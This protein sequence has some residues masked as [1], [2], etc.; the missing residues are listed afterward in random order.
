MLLTVLGKEVNT[1]ISRPLV[2]HGSKKVKHKIPEKIPVQLLKDHPK[3]GSAGEIVRVRPAFM[4]NYLH[5]GNGA[6][7]LTA[8]QGPRIP[9]VEKTKPKDRKQI[10]ETMIDTD[11]ETE[12]KA[13]PGDANA[14]ALSL[15][16]LSNL[17][18]TM[19]STRKS[20]QSAESSVSHTF[21][22]STEEL[23]Y[24]ASELKQAIPR[25]HTIVLNEN[26]KLPVEKQYITSL[27]YD[28]AGVQIPQSAIKIHESTNNKTPL[29]QIKTAGE[30]TMTVDVPGDRNGVQ[31]TIIVQ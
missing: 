12:I 11:Q 14:G 24:T 31:R 29:N 13:V 21:E 15:D 18:Q 7:Y 25:V 30:F 8:Q 9:V 22:A 19:K 4:R 6:C 2:R 1:L 5:V 27:I 26:V 3:V 23:T 16:E 20:K 17:F 10:T 28:M